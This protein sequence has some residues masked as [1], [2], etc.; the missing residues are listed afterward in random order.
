MRLVRIQREV[1][2]GPAEAAVL[3][4][5]RTDVGGVVAFTG[6]CRD[7]AGALDALELEHYPGMAETEMER[8][9]ATAEERWPLLGLVAIHRF[10]LIRPGE[11]IVLVA[12]AS[13][14][15]AP[16]FAA[17]SFV[18]DVLKTDAPFWKREHRVAETADPRTAESWVAAKGSDDEAAARWR[19]QR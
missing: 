2:D 1:F 5:G 10:G 11:P 9:A 12:A 8:I 14:H 3:A 4:R 17:A 13:A 15:R 19:S 18:M 6:Y 7:E 16:A